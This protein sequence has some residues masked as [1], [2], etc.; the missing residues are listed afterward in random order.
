MAKYEVK[1]TDEALCDM[2]SIYDYIAQ[3]LQV[4]DIA[5]NQYNRI[6]EA[7]LSLDEFPER[8]ELFEL[9]P[10]RTMGIRRMIVDNYLVCYIVDE[11]AVT[12]TD[13]LYGAS[14]IHNRLNYRHN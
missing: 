11:K 13:V 14:D 1:I 2:E 4:P 6:A 8:Y 12:V 7:I 10:E 9:E 5:M 3:E